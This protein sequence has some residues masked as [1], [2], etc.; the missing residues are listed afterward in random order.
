MSSTSSTWRP[1]QR[2]SGSPHM[3]TDTLPDDTEAAPGRG[4]EAWFRRGVGGWAGG[5]RRPQHRQCRPISKGQGGARAA[6][7]LTVRGCAHKV[8]LHRRHA[9]LCDRARQVRHEYERALEHLRGWG[10]AAAGGGAQQAGARGGGDQA[11]A[12]AL[13]AHALQGGSTARRAARRPQAPRPGAGTHPHD[14][15]VLAGVV[16]DNGAAG[17][18]GAA[19]ARG[20]R[21]RWA[22]RQ[23]V[24]VCAEL[25][26]RGTRR[27]GLAALARRAA[28]PGLLRLCGGRAAPP[29]WWG[30]RGCAREMAPAAAG[31]RGAAPS[32]CQRHDPV[33]HLF[34]GE[35]HFLNI[36]RHVLRLPQEGL[37]NSGRGGHGASGRHCSHEDAAAAAPLGWPLGPAGPQGAAAQ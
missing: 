16:A 36:G 35:K 23:R 29:P 19:E 24:C 14:N 1:A 10:G 12:A 2:P 25:V 31:A 7:A 9:L 37:R 6:G 22:G 13:G 28:C 30:G 32:P 34:L 20:R 18:R 15:D 26:A 33:R 3:S 5:E 17:A 27:R 11:R 21:R 4:G 8:D